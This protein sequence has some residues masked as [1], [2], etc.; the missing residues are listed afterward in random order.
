MKDYYSQY[1]EDIA[2][3]IVCGNNGKIRIVVL[4]NTYENIY[5]DRAIGYFELWKM[6]EKAGCKL[7]RF[8]ENTIKITW[9]PE[10]LKLARPEGH[11]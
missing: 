7:Q 10:N 9:Y 2:E 5:V 4:H 1:L 11:L 8:C 6:L 3:D